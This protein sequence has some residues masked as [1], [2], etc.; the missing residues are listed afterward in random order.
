[1]VPHCP[2]WPMPRMGRFAEPYR[3]NIG[4][5]AGNDK[6]RSG[7]LRCAVEFRRILDVSGFGHVARMLQDSADSFLKSLLRAGVGREYGRHRIGVTV[8]RIQDSTGRA[9]GTWA[10][11]RRRRAG[12]VQ[13][14]MRR[15]GVRKR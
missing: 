5:S 12:W 9:S 1:M 11:A 8:S 14:L 3:R 2:P 6:F 15:D 13:G 10:G 7:V 4:H